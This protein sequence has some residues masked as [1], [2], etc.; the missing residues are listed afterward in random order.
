MRNTEKSDEDRQAEALIKF[1]QDIRSARDRAAHRKA[2]RLIGKRQ[3]RKLRRTA[4]NE[5]EHSAQRDQ[6]DGS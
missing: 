5:L 3:Y 1:D 4:L 2:V 6:E